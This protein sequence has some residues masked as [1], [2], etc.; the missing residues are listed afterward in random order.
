MSRAISKYLLGVLA[1][2]ALLGSIWSATRAQAEKGVTIDGHV[3]QLPVVQ[4]EGSRLDVAAAKGWKVLYFWSDG[5]PCVKRCEQVNFIPLSK[6]FKDEVSFYGVASNAANI[7][8]R[9]IQEEGKDV[10]LPLLRVPGSSGFWPP[11]PV[12]VDARHKVADLLGAT[13]T[14]EVFLFS[15]DNQLVYRGVPDDSKEYEER[16]GKRGLTQNY[17]RDAL[18]DAMAGKKVSRP[19]MPAKAYC[20][21]DRTDVPAK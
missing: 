12:V 5:C 1:T 4:L 17:L 14:P 21:I 3:S 16:T 6:E 20:S 8:Y 7:R 13:F 2:G 15:P 18:V 10:E 9:T 19:T 11:Y